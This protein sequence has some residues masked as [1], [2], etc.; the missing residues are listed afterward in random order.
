MTATIIA[1][2]FLSLP[3]FY[4]G[5]VTGRLQRRAKDSFL[6]L[7]YHRVLTKQQVNW[8]IQPGMYVYDSTLKMQL[9]FLKRYFCVVDL[10]VLARIRENGNMPS[11]RPICA[12]TF[13]DGWRDFYEYAYPL[14]RSFE[15]PAT[16]FLPTDFIG[17]DKLFWT[18]MVPDVLEKINKL[19]DG[20]HDA[21]PDIEKAI[22]EIRNLS[23]SRESI[24]EKAIEILKKYRL[25]Q[26]EKIFDKIVEKQVDLQSA[27]RVFLNWE[28]VRQM[29]NSGL[30]SFGSHTH[31][32]RILTTL[33]SGEVYEELVDSRQKLMEEKACDSEF[34]PFCYPNGNYDNK[35]IQLVKEAGYSMAVTTKNGWNSW[36]DD[37]YSLKRIGIHN[38]MSFCPSMFGL[39]LLS[40]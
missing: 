34:I 27:E 32:H 37:F 6:I 9:M 23:G 29:K 1:R 11:G 8:R 4:L 17:S 18:D 35:I 15:I 33:Q 25:E 38:D 16:V 10:S 24:L 28:Q 26:I 20:G 40:G 3:L 19:K 7:M 36:N 22:L 5:M 12:I 39:R 21:D 2:L 31:S 14:L 13:D 30:V